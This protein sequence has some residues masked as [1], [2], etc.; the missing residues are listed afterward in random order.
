MLKEPKDFQLATANRIL[1]VFQ[2]GQK[3]VLLADEVGLGKTVVASK[4]IKLVGEW[5]RTDPDILDDHFK[6]VYVC[7]NA[8]IANQNAHTL[9]VDDTLDISE[10]RLSMQHLSIYQKAG[11]DH[12][13]EQLIPLTPSTSFSMTLGCGNKRERALL[14]VLLS[15]LDSFADVKQ[16]FSRFMK[17]NVENGWKEWIEEYENQVINCD[18]NGSNYLEEMKAA[19]K[20]ILVREENSDII[21]SILKIL[22][23]KHP[24]YICK[25]SKILINRLRRI[26]AEISLA[27]MDPDLVIMDEFQRFRNLIDE[28][29]DNS[30]TNMLVKKFFGNPNTKI[31]LLSATP[32]KPY[33]TL[34][35]LNENNVDEQYQDFLS[36]MKF[37][38]TEGEDKSKYGI[39]QQVWESYSK[40]LSQLDGENFTIL[41][42]S[43]DKAEEAM[44]RVMCRTERINTGIVDDSKALE[45]PIKIG[46]IL[47]YN[48]LQRIMD[49]SYERDLKKKNNRAHTYK[50][51]VEYIK[52]TPFVLSFTDDYDLKKHLFEKSF[53]D[54]EFALLD[55][56][57]KR[58]KFILSKDNI[59]FYREFECNNARLE[60]LKKL[61]FGDSQ[62]ECL[63]WVPASHPYYKNVGGVFEKNKDFSKILVFSAWAMVPRMLATMLSYEAERLTIARIED[64]PTYAAKRGA[65]YGFQNEHGKAIVKF[66]SAK[67]AELYNPQEYY[68]WDLKNVVSAVRSK[69]NDLLD[70]IASEYSLERHGNNTAIDIHRLLLFIEGRDFTEELEENRQQLIIPDYAADILT[71]IAIASPASCFYRIFKNEEN[72]T[73]MAEECAN[74]FVT[75]FNRRESAAAIYKINN[76]KDDSYYEYV[77]DYC[78]KGNLQS[79]LDEY[80]FMIG[81]EGE[82]L[83]KELLDGFVGGEASLQVDTYTSAGRAPFRMRTHYALSYA[84]TKLDDKTISR[85]L[86][87][88][89]VFNSPFRP[90]VL[91]ST[92]VGQEGLD[93]HKYARKIMHW[94]LPANPVELEQ[95]EGRVNRFLNLSV[96]RNVAHKYGQLFDWNEMLEAAKRDYKGN[97]CEMV[98][99]WYL[100]PKMLEDMRQEDIPVEKIERIVAMYPLSKDKIK[101]DRLIKI[102]T[103]YRLTMGQPRQEELLEM[104]SGVVSE[105]QIEKLLIQLSPIRRK[106]HG[107]P[108]AKHTP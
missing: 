28:P 105:E 86:N 89:K 3:R 41:K 11:K 23:E 12:A 22:E 19:L 97:D 81:K 98:P 25:E 78:V 75:M 21:P 54:D 72:R 62:S 69:V 42:A 20:D 6:V 56:V 106:N 13:Y 17:M 1:E 108:Y 70:S 71:N 16:R 88:Q 99:Y 29:D 96:R 60:Y 47:S 48:Q 43:K 53:K 33:S 76:R 63:L 40:N 80:A 82:E 18:A 94:N 8:N 73:E 100:P 45:I 93:F 38:H 107:G 90:F 65:K 44:Y 68:G 35:E 5:H 27:K 85:N 91:A 74:E 34:E 58:R 30:E 2:G 52:S 9:G 37:L 103:L 101:Y 36:L 84:N 39:F 64:T 46:D 59:C 57:K 51:P 32:Y 95:R 61:L 104:L 26:F 87:V 31:L 92:S 50:V 83:K 7:S 49:A 4:V 102:L 67:V 79:V 15:R 14:Y 66:V 77:L 24:S 10:S 55:T